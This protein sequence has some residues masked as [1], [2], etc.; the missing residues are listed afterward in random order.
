MNTAPEDQRLTGLLRAARSEGLIGPGPVS[1]HIR[2]A[3]GYLEFLKDGA[4]IDLGS[5][6]GLPGL[7]IALERPQQEI[8]LLD[9]KASRCEWLRS[10]IAELGLGNATV[11]E[12]QA[13]QLARRQDLQHAFCSVVARGFGGPAVLA[14]CASGFLAVGGRLVVS[15]P[16]DRPDRWDGLADS[17]LGFG[18]AEVHEVAGSG[19]FAVARLEAEGHRPLP[20]TFSAIRKRPRF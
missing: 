15:E 12:G 4:T 20:R 11:L 7:V 17:P 8:A 2:H 6:A 10:A 16:P 19:H 14:E 18:A 5:G 13:E 1:T 3:H 9:M